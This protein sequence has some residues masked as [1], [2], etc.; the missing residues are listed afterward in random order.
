M[1]K[2]LQYTY[3]A[4]TMQLRKQHIQPVKVHKVSCYLTTEVF[5]AGIGHLAEGYVQQKASET[6]TL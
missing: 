2:W 6:M 1:I 3:A 4:A 5:T